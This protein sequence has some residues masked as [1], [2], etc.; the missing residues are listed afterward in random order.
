MKKLKTYRLRFLI[1]LAVLV[2]VAVGYFTAGGI[3][4]FC[5]IGF[6]S[7]TLLCPC[8]LYTSCWQL[9]GRKYMYTSGY[10]PDPPGMGFGPT[11]TTLF[12]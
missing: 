1:M 7:I 9:M 4:N 10:C 2:V 6:E 12:Q 11:R 8:L 3:G 5:G